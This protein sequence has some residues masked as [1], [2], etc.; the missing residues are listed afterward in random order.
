MSNF[1]KI[2]GLAGTAVV[3]AGMAF[4]Q[5]PATC[6]NGPTAPV[7][8]II[9]TEGTSELVASIQFTCTAPLGGSPAGQAAVQVFIT[10]SLPV[11]SKVLSTSTGNTEALIQVNGAAPGSNTAGAAGSVQ[12]T[13][14]GSTINFSGINLPG[15]A[16]GA[17]YTFVVSNVR[18]N[19]TTLSTTPG[20]PPQI[21]EAVFV[22]GS[23][24][25][26][27]PASL[28]A[29]QVAFAQ[30]GLGTAAIY[31]TFTTNNTT[32]PTTAFPQGVGST[33]GGNSFVICNAYSPVIDKVDY[34]VTAAGGIT[35]GK[36]LAFAVRVAEN[37]A[38]AFKVAGAYGGNGVAGTAGT[39]QSQVGVSSGST[40]A[41][42]DG[43]RFQITFANVPANVTLYVPAGPITSTNSSTAVAQLTASAAGTAFAAVTPSTSS[44]SITGS[45]SLTGARGLAA[46]TIASGTGTAVFE[47]T[48]ADP[49]NL[50][51][52]DIPVFAVSTANAVAGGAT[53]VTAAVSFNPIGSTVIPNF[54]AGASTTTLT[55]STFGLCTTSLLFPFVT[56]QLGFDTGIAISNTSTD[57][58][59]STLGATPQAGTCTLNF[60]GAGAPSPNSVPLPTSAAGNT[61]TSGTTGA[62]VLSSVAAGFQGYIIAQCAF[63]YAHGFAFITNGPGGLSQGYLAGVIPDVN[64]KA[65]SADP[66]SI[67]AAGTGE[68]LGN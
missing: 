35:A 38:S 5:G 25:T 57:P 21:T 11:T 30:N 13:V 60:Y 24:T 62:V 45:T 1:S 54:A 68:T 65:R 15:I 46:V 44:G 66:L 37:F 20:A 4:G 53:A 29:Q 41:V 34:S 12:G 23:V 27:I 33:A 58:F 9:R 67:A 32:A 18:V 10:P 42:V 63:Q 19:A 61:V 52:F 6:V 28:A 22:S 48:T 17:T 47:I 14:S 51:R 50:D 43:T 7:T 26:I 36:S 49:T 59:G 8:N 2:F 39:E 55:G 56:N 64:Q 40:N 3:F 16:A 31:K